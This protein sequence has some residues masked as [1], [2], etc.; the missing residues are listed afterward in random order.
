MSRRPPEPTAQDL[1]AWAKLI[2]AAKAAG[3][4]PGA[5]A[6]D[7]D[8]AARSARRCIVVG[9]LAHG[10]PFVRLIRAARAFVDAK[11]GQRRVAAEDLTA[12]A[13]ECEAILQSRAERPRPPPTGDPP[14][15]R[16][17]AD[18]DG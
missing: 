5:F 6:G 17:C 12:I 10:N 14:R 3:V 16:P 8:L 11:P 4:D 9:L 2:R 18:I 15:L 1:R 13:L 7:L